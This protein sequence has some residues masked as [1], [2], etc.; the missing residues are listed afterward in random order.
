MQ[1]GNLII[2]SP[3]A[4]MYKNLMKMCDKIDWVGETYSAS[5]SREYKEGKSKLTQIVDKND[6]EGK[7]I[8]I[9]DDICVKGGTFVG[10]AKLLRERN[11]GKLYLAVSHLTLPEVSKELVDSFDMIFTTNSK[12]WNEY[13][14][15]PY[16]NSGH[17][18]VYP[19]LAENIKVIK[20]FHGN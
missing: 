10:L 7:D 6:F 18:K 20:M 14:V 1:I 15:K 2:L 11:V 3:D 4:G 8:L 12:G 19:Q 5:K 13:F 9:V 17:D 16:E